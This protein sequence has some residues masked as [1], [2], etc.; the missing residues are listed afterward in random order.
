MLVLFG[1]HVVRRPNTSIGQIHLL[2]QHFGYS[3]IPQLDLL[4]SDEYVGSFEVAVQDT[5]VMHVE[6]SQGDLDSPVDNLLLLKFAAAGCFLLLDDE[7]VEISSGAELHD[8]V[9]FQPID[10][11]LAVGD[12]VDVLE[13]LQKFDLVEDVFGL[14]AAL[15]GQLD[16]FDHVVLGLT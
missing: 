4:V 11:G 14:L 8:D 3:E 13:L 1:R 10:N 5:L 2:V 16:L 6:D 12:D 9:E 7:L 15:V